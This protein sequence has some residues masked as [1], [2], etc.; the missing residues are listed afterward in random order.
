MGVWIINI[1]R[2]Y[3]VGVADIIIYYLFADLEME[4]IIQTKLLAEANLW[5]NEKISV[6]ISLLLLVQCAIKVFRCER[7]YSWL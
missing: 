6:H 1:V 2:V 7:H 3:I 4:A 5:E